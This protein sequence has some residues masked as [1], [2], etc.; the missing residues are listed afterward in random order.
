MN[1]DYATRISSARR[2]GS[3]FFI[4]GSKS[5]SVAAEVNS[6]IPVYG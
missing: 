6:W 2:S 5:G 1:A 4:P 3:R